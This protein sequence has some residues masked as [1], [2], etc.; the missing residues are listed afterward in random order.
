MSGGQIISRR[1]EN[2]TPCKTVIPL[3][4]SLKFCTCTHPNYCANFGVNL[5]SGRFSKVGE[6]LENVTITYQ[7]NTGA[8]FI[9]MDTFMHT[10][11]YVMRTDADANVKINTCKYDSLFT[12]YR[13]V[14]RRQIYSQKPHLSTCVV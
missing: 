3:K 5:F 4:F 11:M 1:I 8:I 14:K 10:A 12:Q 7:K 13:Q 6:I 9:H 2:S